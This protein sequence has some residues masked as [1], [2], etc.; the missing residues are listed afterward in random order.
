M[1]TPS[2]IFKTTPY[3][4][5]PLFK[6]FTEEHAKVE[7]ERE[8]IGISSLPS[9]TSTYSHWI[10]LH[11]DDVMRDVYSFPAIRESESSPETSMRAFAGRIRSSIDN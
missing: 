5:P 8:R 6:K 4:G 2:D 1:L 7:A 9:Y 3:L 11:D 10:R